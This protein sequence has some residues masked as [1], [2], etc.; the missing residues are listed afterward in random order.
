MSRLPED[1]QRNIIHLR[2]KKLPVVDIAKR[3]N[4]SKPTIVKYCRKAG[5]SGPKNHSGRPKKLSVKAS[6]SLCRVFLHNKVKSLDEGKRLVEKKFKIS[7]SRQTISNCLN[8]NNIK[9]YT[10]VKK[11]LLSEK[12]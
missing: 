3:L 9:C 5:I 11:P 10:K 8:Y 12:H 4:L 7:V 2:K 1:V 6:N